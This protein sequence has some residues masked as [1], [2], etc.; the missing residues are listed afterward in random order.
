MMMGVSVPALDFSMPRQLPT[1]GSVWEAPGVAQRT[2]ARAATRRAVEILVMADGSWLM[3]TLS[4][5]PHR[6]GLPE[7]FSHQPFSHQPCRGQG[8]EVALTFFVCLSK[9]SMTAPRFGG[10]TSLWSPPGTSM[11]VNS[12]PSAF[13]FATMF[14]DPATFTVGSASPCTMISGTARM[15]SSESGAPWPESGA[16]A[17]QMSGYFGAMSHVPMPP[18]EWP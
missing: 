5:E 7:W 17:A 11:Y 13:S 2:T 9:N 10:T 3:A 15:R 14:R 6:T 12:V 16:M 1:T 8:C 4:D 18:I